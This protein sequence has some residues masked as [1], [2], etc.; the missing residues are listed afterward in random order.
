M[1]VLSGCVLCKRA[2]P[3]NK[4]T[5]PEA[6]TLATTPSSQPPRPLAG[7][8][9][10]DR[11]YALIAG[12]LAFE[13]PSLSP[14]SARK[15]KDQELHEVLAARGVPRR[16]LHLLLDRDVTAERVRSALIRMAEGAGEGSTLLFYYAGHGMRDDAGNTF[17]AAYDTG[18]DLAS[19][20][21]SLQEVSTILA[22]RFRGARVVLMA[23]CCYSG[24][25]R[26]V[27]RTLADTGI[28]TLSLTSA[29]ASNLSTSNW[30]F[31]QTL[32]DALAGDA[33]LDRNRDGTITLGEV[34]EEVGDAMK[35][36]EKQRHGFFVHGVPTDL[37]WARAKGM[38]PVVKGAAYAPGRYVEAKVDGRWEP[39]RVVEAD[40]TQSVVRL[41]DYCE[42][43]DR[44]IANAL[45]RPMRFEHYA[46]GS[47]VQVFWG[48]RIWP[49]RITVV[50]GDFHRITYPGWSAYWDEWILS[51]RIAAAP[52]KE[53]PKVTTGEKV[54]VEWQGRWYPALVLKRSGS[55]ALIHYEGYDATWDEWVGPERMRSR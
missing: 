18:K 5:R 46:V 42:S 10:S 41:Y 50:E 36:R 48:G 32:I 54:D 22:T 23:D 21:I 45:L 12:V 28:R 47:D 35:H 27:A 40:A 52:E 20:A 51:N 13:S 7:A 43:E 30:T 49:A 14:F 29:D 34:D 11:T 9:W 1:V 25:L 38:V 37:A 24:S 19:T 26:R 17:F 6:T 15:R 33:L 16:N 2:D 8:L 39:A 55:R 53:L 4:H 44:K 3:G 31:T